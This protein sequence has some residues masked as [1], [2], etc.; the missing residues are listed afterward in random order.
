[1][2]EPRT[3]VYPVFYQ[4]ILPDCLTL[5]PWLMAMIDSLPTDNHPSGLRTTPPGDQLGRKLQL[6]SYKV[7]ISAAGIAVGS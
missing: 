4:I 7:A 5:S 6:C 1:M 3:A 2:W